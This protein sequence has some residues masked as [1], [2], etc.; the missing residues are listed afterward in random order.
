MHSFLRFVLSFWGICFI[1]CSL[2]SIEAE[3]IKDS[4]THQGT[5]SY[6][7]SII[8]MQWNIGHFSEGKSSGS[9]ITDASYY[10][11]LTEY[12]Q[13][14][15][16]V[17]ADVVSLCEYS[18]I[19]AN[20]ASH[21]GCYADTCLFYDYPFVFIGN[22]GRI[23]NYSLNAIMSK[24]EITQPTT[25]NYVTNSTAEITHTSIIKATDYYYNKAYINIGGHEVALINTHLA[26]DTNNPDV[27]INQIKELIRVLQNEEYVVICGD[28][29]TAASSYSLFT[30]AGYSLANTGELGTFPSAKTIAPLDNIITK[31]LFVRNVYLVHSSLSDHYPIVCTISAVN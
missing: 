29:N 24:Q 22:N 11:K 25:I 4:K 28:F 31:G 3:S 16:D 9:L 10:N 7:D 2:D 13:L 20:T 5:D 15:M 30:Q 6:K 21:P 8:V 27:A 18:L 19:F 1:A 26:F 17:S 14:I 12:R 23:R